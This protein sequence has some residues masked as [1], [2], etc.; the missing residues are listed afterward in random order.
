M[1][2][3]VEFGS[4]RT[5]WGVVM[6]AA[7]QVPTAAFGDGRAHVEGPWV[8]VLGTSKAGTALGPLPTSMPE[9][10]NIS[11]HR[12]MPLNRRRRAVPCGARGLAWMKRTGAAGV[13]VG[14][15]P[16]GWHQRTYANK[17]A[18][19]ARWFS[20]S[21]LSSSPSKRQ[22]TGNQ[23]PLAFGSSPGVPSAW[24]GPGGTPPPTP[25]DGCELSGSHSESCRC[26]L[27]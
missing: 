8:G 16:R 7:G 5:R 20:R 13:Y 25:G 6:A 26:A 9:E 23:G 18:L 1:P 2:L 22:S 3:P 15:A 4:P 14:P 27:H 10:K 24:F 21:P 11:L 17:R 19:A 12:Q